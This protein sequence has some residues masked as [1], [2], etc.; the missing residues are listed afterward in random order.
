M[1]TTRTT[2]DTLEHPYD[3]IIL[4]NRSLTISGA[5]MTPADTADAR[6]AWADHGGDTCPAGDPCWTIALCNPRGDAGTIHAVIR[7]PRV[8]R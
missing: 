3:L 5:H 8:P 7:V 2:T 6:A 4:P 1:T